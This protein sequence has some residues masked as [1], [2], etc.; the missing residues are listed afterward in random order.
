[1]PNRS[2]LP[3]DERLSIVRASDHFREWHSL[4]DRRFCVVCERT[5]TGR[6]V[7]ILR[8]R[9]GGFRL[10]CPTETCKSEPNQWICPG[11]PHASNQVD[12]DWWR[13]LEPE[14]QRSALAAT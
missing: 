1:M 3:L 2:Y 11:N 9:S 12:L 8:D 14:N 4:D 10:R 6:Q 7:R 13:A 5:F